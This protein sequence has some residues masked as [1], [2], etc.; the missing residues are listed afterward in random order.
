MYN[1]N[2]RS[3]YNFNVFL[4]LSF[5][6]C[7]HSFFM[8]ISVARHSRT[9]NEPAWETVGM[10]T[11]T[12]LT[13]IK[14][15]TK[16]PVATCRLG[17]HLRWKRLQLKASHLNKV[18]EATNACKI[19]G[20]KQWLESYFFIYCAGWAI[21]NA[22]KGNSKSSSQPARAYIFTSQKQTHMCVYIH[23]LYIHTYTYSYYKL[24]LNTVV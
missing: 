13:V 24:E 3:K 20:L 11:A 2:W 19:C 14:I 21:D 8:H 15:L 16:A 6:L 7:S 4:S 23:T 9:L 5:S 12:K 18:S 10:G 22:I 17:K 1:S